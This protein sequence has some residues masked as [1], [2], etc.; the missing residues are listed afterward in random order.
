MSRRGSV[1]RGG[2]TSATHSPPEVTLLS[3]ESARHLV[4]GGCAAVVPLRR[5]DTPCSLLHA[6]TRI[7][8]AYCA[9]LIDDYPLPGCRPLRRRARGRPPD[10]PATD[11]RPTIDRHSLLHARA[12][13]VHMV[14][15]CTKADNLCPAVGLCLAVRRRRRAPF[16]DRPTAGDRPATGRPTDRPTD[17]P[18]ATP[19]GPIDARKHITRAYNTSFHCTPAE[20]LSPPASRHSRHSCLRRPARVPLVP[21]PSLDRLALIR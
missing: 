16:A 18:T 9:V 3:I 14:L 13:L 6:R 11:R 21:R 7:T 5:P 4:A 12:S 17:R 15:H 2:A 20:Y 8:R 1:R 19:H 10:R